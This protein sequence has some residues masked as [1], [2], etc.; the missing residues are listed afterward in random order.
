[1]KGLTSSPNPLSNGLERGP[2][3]EVERKSCKLDFALLTR[4]S[5]L[6]FEGQGPGVRVA[7]Q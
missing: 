5:S 7:W 3:G 6:L 2:G 4:H 1:M